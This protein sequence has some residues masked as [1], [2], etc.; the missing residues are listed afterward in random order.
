MSEHET[1]PAP[2]DSETSECPV[3]RGAPKREER[4]EGDDEVTF[5]ISECHVCEAGRVSRDFA[6]SWWLYTEPAA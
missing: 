4:V 6:R 5:L 3:C 2:P 1:L